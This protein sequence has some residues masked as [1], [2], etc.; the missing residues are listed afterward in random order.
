MRK[1]SSEQ[2]QDRFVPIE[3]AIG[4]RV[5]VS[6]PVPEYVDGKVMIDMQALESFCRIAGV[7]DLIIR[8]KQVQKDR[9]RE[10][11]NSL[12]PNVDGSSS[13]GNIFVGTAEKTDHSSVTTVDT[14]RGRGLDYVTKSAQA[15]GLMIEVDMEDVKA[16]VE[17][18]HKGVRNA[19]AW[20]KGINRRVIEQFGKAGS[21][22]LLLSKDILN[23]IFAAVQVGSFAEFIFTAMHNKESWIGFS[24]AVGAYAIGWL[25]TVGKNIRSGNRSR[26]SACGPYLPEFDRAAY[27]KLKSTYKKFSRKNPL[28]KAFPSL[29]TVESQI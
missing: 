3:R 9:L 12:N 28:I 11:P 27:L 18:S 17:N 29:V 13:M 23:N 25:A 1:E 15:I 8:P 5:L 14:A 6:L 24:A 26:F 10:I 20:A 21:Q 2:Q 4:Q 19:D 7:S 22:N 16:E